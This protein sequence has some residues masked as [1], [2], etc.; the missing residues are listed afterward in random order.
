LVVSPWDSV[1]RE[2]DSLRFSVVAD[3]G[4]VPVTSF[5]VAWQTSDSLRARVNAFGLVRAPLR[6]DTVT[7][8]AR[9][10]TAVRD[11]TRVTFVP[12]ATAFAIAG[13]NT[14]RAVVSTA[15]AQPLRVRVTAGDGLGVKGVSVQFQAL[16]AGGS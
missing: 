5:Y 1:I 3:A 15:L 16:G 7:I 10:L 6:R 13:G 4:G 11:S 8:I 12:L 14:Q 2:G 9:T